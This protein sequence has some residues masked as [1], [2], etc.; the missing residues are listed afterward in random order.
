MLKVEGSSNEKARFQGIA[1]TH[2]LLGQARLLAICS[3][4][5]FQSVRRHGRKDRRV[6]ATVDLKLE[7]ND[8]MQY[9]GD[10]AA[11]GK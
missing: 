3:K 7:E 6:L 11:S 1:P 10:I 5:V 2:L 4:V 8:G 9:A